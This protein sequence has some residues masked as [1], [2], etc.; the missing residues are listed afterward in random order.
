[1]TQPSSRELLVRTSRRLQRS[2]M[3][4]LGPIGLTSVQARVVRYLASLG[5][6]ARMAD[7]AAALE[8]VPRSVTSIVDDLERA[9]L[10]TRAIDPRD[11]R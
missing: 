4:E 6:P 11:R 2:S 3:A 9:N 1:M 10:V 8:V 5:H 7:I